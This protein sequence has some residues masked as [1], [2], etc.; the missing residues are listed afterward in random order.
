MYNLNLLEQTSQKL[1]FY[2]N[3]KNEG[4]QKMI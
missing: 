3:E 4:H 1:Q 2:N